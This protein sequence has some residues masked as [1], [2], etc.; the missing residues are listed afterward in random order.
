[1][2][3]YTE[4]SVRDLRQYDVFC[5]FP[6]TK[7]WQILGQPIPCPISMTIDFKAQEVL[8]IPDGHAVGKSDFFELKPDS[9]VF[10]V[11]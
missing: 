3:L 8:V 4:T 2:S 10:V 9:T 7:M 5:M 6:A 1:M 11:S